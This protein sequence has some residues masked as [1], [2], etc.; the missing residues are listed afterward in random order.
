ML[1]DA[2]ER[3][4]YGIGAVA[5]LASSFLSSVGFVVF[6]LG[7]LDLEKAGLI[8]TAVALFALIPFLLVKTVMGVFR[9]DGPASHVAGGAIAGVGGFL[10]LLSHGAAASATVAAFFGAWG[11]LAGLIYW[12]SRKLGRR[13]MF[14]AKP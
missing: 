6:E 10:L 4:T 2:S 1:A 8:G 5:Y 12:C 7:K 11:S 13:L 3:G 14:G 9:K